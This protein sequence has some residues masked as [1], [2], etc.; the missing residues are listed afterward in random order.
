MNN[1]CQY[2]VPD[3]I[4]GYNCSGGQLDGRNVSKGVCEACLTGKI[5]K[6]NS[7]ICNTDH[8]DFCNRFGLP[9]SENAC[10]IC[11][12]N[13]SDPDFLQQMRTIGYAYGALTCKYRIDSQIIENKVCCGGKVKE[14]IIYNCSLT[15]E[16]ANC[17]KC[18]KKEIS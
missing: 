7:P 15:N 2:A 16:K 3:G 8:V 10:A 18:I 4:N 11:N 12:E 17:I 5:L 1:N 13:K 6:H 14:I 9:T